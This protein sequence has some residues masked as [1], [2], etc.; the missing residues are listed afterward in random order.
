MKTI[1]TFS[2][3][4]ASIGSADRAFASP[5]PLP[6]S[7]PY[8]TLAKGELELALYGDMTPLRVAADPADLT[9]GRLWE[10]AYRLQNEIEYG[11]SDRTEL[12]FYQVFEAQPV[13]GGSNA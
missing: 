11:V 7:Y 8:E 9:K 3:V 4:L 12:A 5:R 2:V 13:D 10:P 6:F 1:I